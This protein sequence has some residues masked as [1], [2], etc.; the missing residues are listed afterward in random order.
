[1]VPSMRLSYVHVLFATGIY[2]IQKLMSTYSGSQRFPSPVDVDK[3]QAS[4]ENGMLR[5]TIPKTE[6]EIKRQPVQIP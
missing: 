4:Y 6:K 1:M 3:V 2:R 5:L